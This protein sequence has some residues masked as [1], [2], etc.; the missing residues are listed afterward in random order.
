VEASG[1]G[2]AL[3]REGPPTPGDPREPLSRLAALPAAV[4][5]VLD[6]PVH[7]R[8]AVRLAGEV[9][10][11][12]P[13]SEAPSLLRELAAAGTAPQRRETVSS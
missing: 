10:A 3:R 8:A 7:R 13:V 1:C 12:A 9:A 2:I 4:R 6:E 11:R 5:R